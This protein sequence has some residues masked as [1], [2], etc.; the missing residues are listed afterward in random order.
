MLK[1][2]V[3]EKKVSTAAGCHAPACHAPSCHGPA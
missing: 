3:V 1:I 2:E